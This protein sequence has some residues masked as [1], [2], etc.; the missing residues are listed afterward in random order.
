MKSGTRFAPR[1]VSALVAASMLGPLIG[2]GRAPNNVQA[3]PPNAPYG[4]TPAPQRTG[5]STGKK[6]ALLAGTAA[7]IYMYNK[8]KNAQGQ[9]AQG[10]YY[11]SK[12]G[13]VYYRD[14]KGNAVWVT[15]PPQGIQVPESEA[16]YYQQAAR[17]NNWNAQ[18][19]TVG[20]PGAMVPAATGMQSAPAPSGPP[21]PPGPRR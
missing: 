19:G 4:F 2:C 9:G 14:A 6:L 13:R 18:Y 20:G 10:K 7:L 17:S 12:N 11:L 15:P 16:Q 5:M 3:A 8:H 1:A 21:G